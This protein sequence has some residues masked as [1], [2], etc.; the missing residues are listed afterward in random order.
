MKSP[1]SHGGALTI[2]E[3][4]A[5]AGF[6]PMTISR[7]IDGE[8]NVWESTLDAINDAIAKLNYSHNL[9]A[10]TLAGAEQIRIGLLSCNPSAAYRRR[11]FARQLRSDPNSSSTLL[12]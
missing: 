6:S 12:W 9:A 8:Q 2:A 5:E 7:V 10:R 1:R 3:V 4:A 11:F